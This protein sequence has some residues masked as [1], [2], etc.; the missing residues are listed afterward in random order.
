MRSDEPALLHLRDVPGRRD[1]RVR[2]LQV[3]DAPERRREV[4]PVFVDRERVI[5]AEDVDPQS[6][7]EIIEGRTGDTLDADRLESKRP[8]GVPDADHLHVG[9]LRILEKPTLLR[10]DVS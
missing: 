5:S 10:R 3:T 9:A 2:V 4:S 1:D 6:R 7:L 8:Y